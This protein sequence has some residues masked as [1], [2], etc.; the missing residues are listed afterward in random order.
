MGAVGLQSKQLHR[1][2]GV[3]GDGASDV[4]DVLQALNLDDAVDLG[5]SDC[6]VGQSA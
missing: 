6:A 2:A 5:S 1:A 3:A 4:E